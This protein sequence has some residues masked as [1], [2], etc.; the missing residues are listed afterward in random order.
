MFKPVI[1]PPLCS[2]C[3]TQ[4]V[5]MQKKTSTGGD[6]Y[7]CPNWAPNNMGCTGDGLWFPPRPQQAP[8]PYQQQQPATMTPQQGTTII[9]GEIRDLLKQIRDAVRPAQA[10]AED[11]ENVEQEPTEEELQRAEASLI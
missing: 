1:T 8:A 2:K 3:Q 5:M 6:M 4:K 7:A 9:L 11:W 10:P